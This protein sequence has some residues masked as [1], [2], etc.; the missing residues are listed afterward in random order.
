[1]TDPTRRR[2]CQSKNSRRSPLASRADRA[3]PRTRAL[4]VDDMHWH[5]LHGSRRQS[6]RLGRP[7]SSS[8]LVVRIRP[9]SS[10]HCHFDE[11]RQSTGGR[12]ACPRARRSTL[13]PAR[14]G[15]RRS[16]LSP[17]AVARAS[18]KVTRDAVGLGRAACLTMRE[19]IVDLTPAHTSALG[20]VSVA[21]PLQQHG[22]SRRV[23]SAMRRDPSAQGL[24]PAAAT[25]SSPGGTR[26]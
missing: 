16:L 21:S 11:P 24:R 18:R 13:S 5:T 23:S 8:D 7:N 12:A 20:L 26:A 10:T 14:R 3:P 17:R 4:A 9:T 15:Q 22:A 6:T 1:M 25:S 2:R 19:P